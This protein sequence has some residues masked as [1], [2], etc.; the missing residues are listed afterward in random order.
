MRPQDSPEVGPQDALGAGGPR[1]ALGRVAWASPVAGAK[2]S[3]RVV[4]AHAE[5]SRPGKCGHMDTLWS[6]ADVL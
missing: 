4:S 1:R 6:Q 3:P 2:A 5:R